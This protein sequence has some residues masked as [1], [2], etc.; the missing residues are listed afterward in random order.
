MRVALFCEDD[1]HAALLEPLIRRVAAQ[2]GIDVEV[3]VRNS[4]GGAAVALSTLRKYVRDVAAGDEFAQV[5]VV[6]RDGNCRGYQARRK[7]ILDAV[8]DKYPGMVVAAIPEP[9][10]ER[11]YLADPA[12]PARAVDRKGQGDLP[13]QKCER[14]RYKRALRE[15]YQALGIMP[16]AGGIEYGGAIA[17]VMDLAVA[18]K[19]DPAFGRFLSDLRAALRSTAAG[20]T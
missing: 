5:L 16:P 12:A 10:G 18:A 13:A 14:L 9:H 11:W 4:T 7:E 3:E 2:E 6:A 20:A 8:G 1:G 15:A 17:E 19:N